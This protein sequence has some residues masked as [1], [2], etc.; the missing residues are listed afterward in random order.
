MVDMAKGWPMMLPMLKVGRFILGMSYLRREGEL[1]REPYEGIWEEEKKKKQRATSKEA[2]QVQ[3]RVNAKRRW[4]TSQVPRDPVPS[5][6]IMPVD[7]GRDLGAAYRAWQL[8]YDIRG[9]AE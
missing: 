6:R 7:R 8:V 9:G 5:R 1:R 4:L 3:G 2:R